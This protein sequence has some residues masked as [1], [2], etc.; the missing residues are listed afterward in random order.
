M[1]TV[2][3]RKL[4][5]A[6]FPLGTQ[7]TLEEHLKTLSSSPEPKMFPPTSSIFFFF[8]LQTFKSF[9]SLTVKMQQK[10][11]AQWAED[12]RTMMPWYV[13]GIRHNENMQIFLDLCHK[14]IVRGWVIIRSGSIRLPTSMQLP[15]ITEIHE[16]QN[17]FLWLANI[18]TSLTTHWN[19][20]PE[21][22]E[23]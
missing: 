20:P 10:V 11:P 12:M 3:K 4:F 15:A 16:T 5:T 14:S 9:L 18:H 1:H 22:S 23:D 6:P 7:C 19:G 2:L 8:L 17:T 13:L 21:L